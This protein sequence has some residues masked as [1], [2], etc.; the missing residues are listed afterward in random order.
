MKLF[1][2]QGYHA[3]GL[4]EILRDA[5]ARSGSLYHFFASKEDLLLAV[6]DGYAEHM[7]A[8]V[9][10]P[11]RAMTR[12]PIEQVFAVMGGYRRLLESTDCTRGCPIGNLALEAD[13]V[14]AVR[15][16][17]A[18]NFDNWCAAVEEILRAAGGRFRRGT[19]VKALS[20]F[21]LTTMEGGIM[22]AR[23]YRSLSPFDAC[24]EQLRQHM[25]QL[26]KVRET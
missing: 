24:I 20:R 3:T 1:Y 10:E 26:M 17:V 5:N 9:F 4:A 6:L 7:H 11:A 16:K 22:Q 15:E 12:D 25:N 13:D 19:D 14:P 23:A 2:E 21:V 18:M 8:E